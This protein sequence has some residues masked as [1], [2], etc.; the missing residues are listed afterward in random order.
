MSEGLIDLSAARP[1]SIPKK[2]NTIEDVK[3]VLKEFKATMQEAV[4]VRFSYMQELPKAIDS[5]VQVLDG[6]VHPAKEIQSRLNFLD[7]TIRRLTDLIIAGAVVIDHENDPTLLNAYP[8]ML[9][10]RQAV[11]DA[12][13]ENRNKKLEETNLT[14]SLMVA[15]FRDLK[16][17]HEVL[18]LVK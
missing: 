11:I 17:Y 9:A 14:E 5:R 10:N 6:Q 2:Q 15:G 4:D 12:I 8:T 16:R 1:E 7:N 3:E 18:S 13:V